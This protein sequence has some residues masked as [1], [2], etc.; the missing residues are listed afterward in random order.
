MSFQCSPDPPR[1][2][3]SLPGVTCPRG[4]ISVTLGSVLQT[5]CIQSE[6]YRRR[7]YTVGNS[8]AYA[9]DNSEILDKNPPLFFTLN[10]ALDIRHLG[11]VTLT[12]YD[13]GLPT[14][15]EVVIL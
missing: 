2:L 11:K 5:W 4:H 3:R 15:E 8:L 12:Q 7:S 1:Q 14:D 9:V 13:R 6:I 10:C